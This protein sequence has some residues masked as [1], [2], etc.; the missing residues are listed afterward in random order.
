MSSGRRFAGILTLT[1]AALA[2]LT[3]SAAA[4]TLVVHPGQSIQAKIDRA[5]GGDTVLVRSG[6]YRGSL[7]IN[8]GIVLQGQGAVLRQGGRGGSLCNQF[9]PPVGVCVH[10]KLKFRGEDQEPQILRRVRNVRIRGFQIRGFGADGIFA[11][12]TRAMRVRDNR[13]VGNGGY[14]VFSL[15]AIGTRVAENVVR[16]NGGPG[17]YVGD[18][19]QAHAVV[20]HNH[21]SENLGEGI[22]IRHAST[23]RIFGNVLAKNCAGL[24]VLADAPGPAGGWLIAGNR[25]VRNNRA[26]KGEPDEGEPPISGLGIALAGARGTTVQGNV[27]RQHLHRHAS[28]GTG[29]IFVAPGVQGTAPQGVRVRHNLA[30]GNRPDI[31]W[32]DGGGVRFVDNRCRTSVPRRICR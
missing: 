15:R 29:G 5:R 1:A 11:L 20:R 16:L 2:A 8:K 3:G 28:I 25:V 4:R 17:I 10:G 22:L 6:T 31:V 32:R 21:S 14:G 7:E 13:L 9:G 26:C 19:P 23:G 24:L 12:G 27:V 30:L 18:S